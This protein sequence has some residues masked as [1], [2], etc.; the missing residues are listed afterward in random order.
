MEPVAFIEVVGRHGEIAARH[1][2]WRWPIRVGRGYEMDVILDDPFVASA[3]VAI[4]ETPEGRF[5]IE[6]LQ[7][8]NGMF[9]LPASEKTT[10]AEIGPD[11]V[12]RIGH[13]QLRVRPRFHAVAAERP[14]RR[15]PAHRQPLLFL[16]VAAAVVATFLWD[17]YVTTSHRD[18]KALMVVSLLMIIAA[19]AIWI[20]IWALVSRTVGRRANFAAHGFVACAGVLALK[21]WATGTGYL[22]FGFDAVWLD[23]L[24]IVG[25]AALFA[26]VVYRHLRLASRAGRGMHATVAALVSIVAFGGAAMLTSLTAAMDPATQAHSYS[27]KAP[28]FVMVQGVSPTA[29]LADTEDLK[30]AVDAMA[31]KEPHL[32]GDR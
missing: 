2:V 3:H 25:A 15:I 31:A 32:P 14:I 21:G 23:T 10:R 29:Y 6:D 12:V 1:P 16:I 26:Y 17:A 30:R 22:A 27:L 11:D 24:G 7:S 19:G 18:G 28:W 20:A 5:A 9:I 8:L 13:T 4:R